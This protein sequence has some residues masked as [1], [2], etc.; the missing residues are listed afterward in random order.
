MQ[1]FLSYPVRFRRNGLERT[2]EMGALL[3]FIRIAAQTPAGSWQGSA[4]FGFREYLESP[5]LLS[6]LEH[7]VNKINE[8]LRELEMTSYLVETMSLS[9][10]GPGDRALNITLVGLRST[11]TVN[12]S[13]PLVK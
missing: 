7:L 8:S 13:L 10:S 6:N 11:A 9:E 2:G 3:Q 12:L 5:V 4:S 1:S